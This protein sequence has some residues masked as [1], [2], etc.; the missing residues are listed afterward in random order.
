MCFLCSVYPGKIDSP[1]P[2]RAAHLAAPNI[3]VLRY[4]HLGP[5]DK[6]TRVIRFAPFNLHKARRLAEGFRRD[7]PTQRSAL[8][9]EIGDVV[10]SGP[11][12]F[13]GRELIPLGAAADRGL[14]HS[15]PDSVLSGL[16]RF[17]NRP[18]ATQSSM[19]TLSLRMPS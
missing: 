4:Q 19:L 7:L 10:R 15:A 11:H 12:C 3:L 9:A 13:P 8:S 2:P 1:N 6:V 14:V 16:H 17:V 18:Y 5:L